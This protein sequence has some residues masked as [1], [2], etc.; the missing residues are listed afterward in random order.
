M[1]T[2]EKYHAINSEGGL[3]EIVREGNKFTGTIRHPVT[4]EFIYK[5]SALSER[6]LR[7][8]LIKFIYSTIPM[9]YKIK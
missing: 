6:D 9:V 4:G 2:S 5:L 1:N 8:Q 7:S 3:F